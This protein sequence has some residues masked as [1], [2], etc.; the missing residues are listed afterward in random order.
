MN[1]AA[2]LVRAGLLLGI[3]LGGFFDGIVLHQ[4]LQWHNM[5]SAKIPPVDLVAAKVNMFWDGV[6]HAAVWLVTLWGVVALWRASTDADLRGHG[7][8]LAGA[9]LMGWALF[10]IVEGV[11]DHHLLDLHHVREFVVDKAPWDWGFLAASVA[12]GMAGAALL[13]TRA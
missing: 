8:R 11:I 5:L 7:R 1:P 10:N 9:M 12:I 13:R 4:L 2:A 6:F 3:G